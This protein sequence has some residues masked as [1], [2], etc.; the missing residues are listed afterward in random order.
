MP[1]IGVCW[2]SFTP[3]KTSS[4]HCWTHIYEISP[5]YRSYVHQL[6][7]R[8]GAPV[9]HHSLMGKRPV[10]WNEIPR[11]IP[12][13]FISTKNWRFNKR[14]APLVHLWS[15]WNVDKLLMSR[16]KTLALALKSKHPP[17]T[18]RCTLFTPSTSGELC[19]FPLISS[20]IMS[21]SCANSVQIAKNWCLKNGV[22]MDIPLPMD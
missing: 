16:A 12:V 15:A 2:F 4:I 1:P 8:L 18:T 7:H 14:K 17:Q 21:I 22:S 3:K 5:R 10:S 19:G 9:N 11:K 6:S 20:H 13:P